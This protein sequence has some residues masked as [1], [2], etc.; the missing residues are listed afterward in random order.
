MKLALGSL[1]VGISAGMVVNPLT[2]NL[3]SLRDVTGDNTQK[4]ISFIS[5]DWESQKALH[6]LKGD[7]NPADVFSDMIAHLTRAE[8][9]MDYL[10]EKSGGMAKYTNFHDKLKDTNFFCH[11][12]EKQ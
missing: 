8:L 9:E 11:K 3:T 10:I 5:K 4:M 6:N 2:E 1:L 7:P 12:L